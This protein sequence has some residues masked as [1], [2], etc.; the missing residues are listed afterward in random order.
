MAIVATGGLSH[1]VHGERGGFNNPAWDHEFL[2][3]FEKDPEGL[4]N[5]T[6]ADYADA[7]RLE[8]AEIVMWLV[9]RGAMRGAGADACTGA[10]TCRR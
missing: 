6:Q 2:D 4:L 3:L 1:Q 5:M 10:T 8:G 7:G 9:M